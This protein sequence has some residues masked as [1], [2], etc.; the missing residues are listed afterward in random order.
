MRAGNLDRPIEIYSVTTVNDSGAPSETTTLWFKGYGSVIPRA[1]GEQEEA[2]ALRSF[3][4][5]YVI[6]RYKSGMEGAKRV[7]YQGNWFRVL[8]HE[9]IGRRRGLKILCEYIEVKS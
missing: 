6:T 1:G 3:Q 7:K 4:Q 5:I 2:A 9:E 8:S